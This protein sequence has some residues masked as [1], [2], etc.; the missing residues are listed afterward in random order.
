MNWM[1]NQGTLIDKALCK[2]ESVP[3]FWMLRAGTP[4]Y[5]LKTEPWEAPLH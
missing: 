2:V 1:C 3:P 5:S 4:A